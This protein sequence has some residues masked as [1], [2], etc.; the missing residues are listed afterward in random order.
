[1]THVVTDAC[2]RCKYTDCID[3]CPVDC[4]HGGAVMLV[5]DPVACIDCAACV[6]ICPS[7]AIIEDRKPAAAI[8][9]DLNKRMSALWPQMFEHQSALADADDYK[10]QAGKFE[11]Y[12]SEEAHGE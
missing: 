7:K 2:I 3:V 12:F 5:I 4:F 6:P 1:M 9:L 11:R 8:W 10:G